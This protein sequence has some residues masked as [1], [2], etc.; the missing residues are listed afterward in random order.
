[1]ELVQGKKPDSVGEWYLANSLY[2]YNHEFIFHYSVFST[3]GVRGAYEL[4]F[5]IL[6]TVPFSTP[7]EFMAKFWHSGEL[8]R[9]DQIRM[10]RIMFEL[11]PN[12]NKEVIIWAK[13]AQ[14]QTAADAAVLRTVGRG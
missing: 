7:M 12:I 8:G 6:T 11:G 9:E 2:K 3:A 5:L 13:E 1:M 14:T 10:Q 4:D